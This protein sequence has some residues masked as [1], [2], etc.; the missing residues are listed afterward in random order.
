[1]LKDWANKLLQEAPEGQYYIKVNPRDYR[2]AVMLVNTSYP[3]ANIEFN[4]PD[5]FY[6]PDIQT[7]EDLIMDFGTHDIEVVEDNL[8]DFGDYDTFDYEDDIEPF[9]LNPGLYENKSTCCMKC[10]HMHVKGTKCPD[11]TYSKDSPKHCKNRKK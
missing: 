5:T 7:A 3:K 1:M 6:T 9:H 10:G 8:S 2:K 4:D 11:P